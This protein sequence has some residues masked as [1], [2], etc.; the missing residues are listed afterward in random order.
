MTGLQIQYF[1]GIY[2]IVAS[3]TVGEGKFK[4]DIVKGVA[5]VVLFILAIVGFTF[6]K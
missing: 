3:S 4:L 5:G 1:L 6:L 2:F